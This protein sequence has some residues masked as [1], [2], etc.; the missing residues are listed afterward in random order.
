M[1]RTE[2]IDKLSQKLG[3][4][5]PSEPPEIPQWQLPE[6][7]LTGAEERASLFLERWEALGGKGQRVNTIP[8]AAEAI[9]TWFGPQPKWLTSSQAIM[10]WTLPEFAEQTLTHLAWP[11]V[12]YAQIE[13]ATHARVQ[14]AA[15]AE[16]GLTGADWGIARTGTL[17]LKSASDR[18]RAVSL[19]PPRHLAFLSTTTIVADLIALM[20]ELKQLEH[21]PAAIELITGPSRTSDIE[22]DLSIGVHGPVEVYVLLTP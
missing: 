15:Q 9:N 7:H 14:A 1:N 6:F 3:R 21:P 8:E 11:L 12:R 19:L 4:P 20:A 10:A 22:M 5:L 2:F 17:V 16:L 18:G 13:E